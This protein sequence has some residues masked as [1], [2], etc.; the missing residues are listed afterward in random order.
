VGSV[1][2]RPV[3]ERTPSG[4]IETL[5]TG[6]AMVNRRP[7]LILVVVA[8]DCLLWLGPR[9]SASAAAQ[10]L[11]DWLVHMGAL[12]AQ[13]A[14]AL[15]RFGAEIDLLTLITSLLPSLVSALGPEAFAL[16]Y[17]PPGIALSLPWA[18][19]SG[20]TMFGIGVVISMAY[21][22][23]LADVVRGE[24]FRPYRYGRAVLRNVGSMLAYL[25][26]ILLAALGLSLVASLVLV[27]A[28][29]VGLE[30][31]ALNFL[32]LLLLVG[33]VAFYFVTFFVEDAIVMSNAGP[34]RSVAYSVGILRVS[35]WPTIRFIVAASVIQL[36]L[37]LALQVFTRNVL[38]VPFA[39]LSY[40][41]IT[42]GLMLASLSFYRERIV[43]VLRREGQRT[44]LG[45]VEEQRS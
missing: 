40:A 27:A 44:Q 13:E 29:L 37:P 36:G 21:L 6:F 24:R 14:A 22:T 42:T 25:G 23:L 20:L 26:L 41:Y 10:S 39:L 11:S 31:V 2:S 4:V 5:G 28:A 35:F 3:R 30:P 45:R 19:A 43:S 38:A 17:Q 9:L 16:P 12:P 18:I 1:S 15:Q 33:A 34:F 8:L 32:T 7:Y